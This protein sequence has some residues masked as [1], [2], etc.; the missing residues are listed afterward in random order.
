M[1][2]EA[3]AQAGNTRFRDRNGEASVFGMILFAGGHHG[4]HIGIEKYAL[5]IVGSDSLCPKRTDIRA[6]RRA[7]NGIDRNGIRLNRIEDTQMEPRG[8]F[9]TTQIKHR[10]Y[11]RR[12]GNRSYGRIERRGRSRSQR[13]E[14]LGRRLNR[15]CGRCRH[16]ILY[17]DG[18][19]LSRKILQHVQRVALFRF[20]MQHGKRRHNGSRQKRARKASQSGP[21]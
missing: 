4:I 7:D 18:I 15:F 12:Q 5:D 20:R 1:D 16:G 2:G 14:R 19:G 8:I 17:S 13:I 9:P 3:L 11:P 6:P 10:L 21:Y